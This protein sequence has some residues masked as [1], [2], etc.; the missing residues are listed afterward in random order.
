MKEL[1]KLNNVMISIQEQPL[2]KE[3]TLTIK[4][5]EVIGIIG[6]NG[7]GKSTLLEV[8]AQNRKPSTGMIQHLQP[9]E[10]AYVKQEAEYFSA[11][12]IKRLWS[13]PNV[14]YENLSGGEKLKFRLMQG[15]Q[16][17]AHILL[18]DEPT[19]HLDAQSLLLLV[20]EIK[21][22]QGAVVIVSH[23]R[24]FLDEVAT[25]IWAIEDEQITS[26]Q[27]NYT[28]YKK[29][30][31]EQRKA[32][33][34]Q[35]EVQQ[36]EFERV[37]QQLANLASW[38]EKAHRQSTKQEGFKEFYRVKAKRMDAQVKSKRKRLEKEFDKHQVE[39]VKEEYAV[40]FSIPQSRK[41]GKRLMELKN[42]SKSYSN[43]H[44]LKHV[45]GTML[46]GDKIALVGPNGAGKTTLLNILMG[47]ETAEGEIWLSPTAQIGYLTQN[48][49][50][51]P[52]DQAPE[53]FFYQP[54]FEGRGK[55]QHLM[56]RLGFTSVQWAQPF[57]SM[58]MGERVKCKLMQYILEQKD[59]LIL[60]EPTNHLDLPSREQLEKTLQHYNGSLLVVSHDRYFVEK[61][62]NKTWEI[63]NGQIK[64]PIAIQKADTNEARRLQ[65]LN[66]QQEILGKLSFMTT[67]HP[68]YAQ[69]NRRF[70]EIVAVL[71]EM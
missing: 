24:H 40:D 50:D 4:E 3:I 59:L 19:N 26:Y 8:I 66:E 9:I 29:Q 5:N 17:N 51:L 32:Q 35:Y 70:N 11:E 34:H 67:S 6:K 20:E 38:S 13:I 60:D 56:K 43:R 18:L 14:S 1:L 23:D 58:S 48:V 31:D 68:E 22:Y 44:L 61:I 39:A 30:R 41:R 55:V 37:E 25:T 65:L 46:T 53:Q 27:G 62:T 36:K 54:T 69:L 15:F 12:Q 7:A 49:F 47:L 2:L 16:A 71:K 21:S 10:I 45:N 52:L 64:A 57:D 33:Q 42:V 63:K 28:T